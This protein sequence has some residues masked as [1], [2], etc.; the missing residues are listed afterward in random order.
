MAPAFETVTFPPLPP[1]PPLPPSVIAAVPLPAEPM[2]YPPPL[3]PPLPTDCANIAV[4][5]AP[6][7]TMEPD[8]LLVTETAPPLLPPAPPVPPMITVSTM[9]EFTLKLP[10]IAPL[11]PPPPT[12]WA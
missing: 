1:L 8:A 5:F 12:D 10:A 2:R 4:E 11:P 3:P 9:D 7:V 6:L